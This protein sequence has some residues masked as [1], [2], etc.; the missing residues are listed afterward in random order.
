M[1][2]VRFATLV[3]LVWWLGAMT[4]ARFGDLFRRTDLVA[5]A[6]G[7]V[8]IVGLLMMKFIGPPP[9]GFVPRAALAILML[10]VAI[11]AGVTRAADT[12]SALLTLNIALG[13]VLL[14]WY[15]RE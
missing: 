12:A 2:V 5:Y 10:A 7:A 11:G 9:H 6:C 8:T 1:I 4:A 3:A 15:V 14:T 13:F